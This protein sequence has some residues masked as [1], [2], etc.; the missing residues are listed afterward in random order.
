VAR[1]LVNGEAVAPP[2]GRS[3]DFVWPRRGVAAFGTDPV[4]ATT[5]EPIVVMRPQPAA[6]PDTKADNR[7][8]ATTG[9]RRTTGRST[10]PQRRRNSSRSAFPFR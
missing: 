9:S 5:T 4:V 1:V 7:G 10:P 6:V 2:A 3:D 8:K